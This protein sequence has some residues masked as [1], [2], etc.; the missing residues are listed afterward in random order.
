MT[1]KT[2]KRIM[3]KSITIYFSEDKISLANEIEQIAK[4]M[5]LSVSTLCFSLI[6]IGLPTMR[7]YADALKGEGDQL[8]EYTIKLEKKSITQQRA[9]SIK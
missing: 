7:H 2:K 3:P 1:A 5:N 8:R 9:E 6:K 4:D